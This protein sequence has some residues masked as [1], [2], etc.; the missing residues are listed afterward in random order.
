MPPV[1]GRSSSEPHPYDTAVDVWLNSDAAGLRS[2]ARNIMYDCRVSEKRERVFHRLGGRPSDAAELEEA[3]VNYFYENV[4]GTKNPHFLSKDMNAGNIVKGIPSGNVLLSRLQ[5]IIEKM[6]GLLSHKPRPG[7]EASDVYRPF[8]FF[9]PELRFTNDSYLARVIDLN[10]LGRTFLWA[11]DEGIRE[12]ETF[13]GVESTDKWLK[14]KVGHSKEQNRAFIAATLKAINRHAEVS[15]FNPSW[16]TLW[17]EFKPYAGAAADRWLELLGIHKTEFPR[18]LIVLKYR[19]SEARRI[20]CPTQLDAGWS[21]FFFPS[22]LRAPLNHPMKLRPAA[23][24]DPL[25]TEL[26]HKQIEH[27]IEHWDEAGG[28]CKDT[29]GVTPQD[30]PRQR[31]AHYQLLINHYGAERI[32]KWMPHC[33]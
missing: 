10:G 25:L 13:E 27:K 29:S 31:T 20:V 33:Y 8:V 11:K 12:F 7:T 28:L 4:R 1:F 21:P 26:I 9:N 22:P 3:I 19:V 23:G 14:R 18:W 15:P 30:L 32:R 5:Y 2:I 6:R 16:A 17:T 24:T